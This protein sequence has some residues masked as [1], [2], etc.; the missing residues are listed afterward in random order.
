MWLGL[1]GNIKQLLSGYMGLGT[2]ARGQSF[3]S[4]VGLQS[5]I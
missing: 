2:M 1:K 3:L 4:E 5:R